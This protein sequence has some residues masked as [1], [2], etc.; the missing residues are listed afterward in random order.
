MADIA[1]VGGWMILTSSPSVLIVGLA[2]ILVLIVAPFAEEPWLNK[3]Y[4]SG[5]EDYAARVRRF[6]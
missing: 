3:Q 1:I 2:A 4:G 5:F 6:L